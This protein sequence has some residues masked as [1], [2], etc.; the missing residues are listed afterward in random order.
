MGKGGYILL[1]CVLLILCVGFCFFIRHQ[2]IKK[3]IV[4]NSLRLIH[5]DAVN[6]S[7]ASGFI[8]LKPIY[9]I[10]KTV[11]S[12]PRFD[13]F[14]FD[15]EIV[16]W[17]LRDTQRFHSIVMKS[18]SNAAL[19]KEY[20]ARLSLSRE[21]ITP[22]ECKRLSIPC[23]Q[24]IKLEE[25]LFNERLF[26]QPVID[27]LFSLKVSYVTPAGRHH[28]SKQMNYTIPHINF[29]INEYQER[30]R[31]VDLNRAERQKMTPSLRYEIL[32]RD[33]FRC[34]ICGRTAEKDGIKLHVDHIIPIS[35]G[36][37]TEPNNLRTLCDECNLGKSN[38]YDEQGDN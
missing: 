34:V 22:E 12:K 14:N 15:V 29:L 35:K 1:S 27:P 11:D 18:N 31:K 28:Y 26:E 17:V 3:I 7:T 6:R 9:T 38:K 5:L 25:K 2:K 8:P 13:K 30:E 4:T 36:G 10:S 23:K 21:S 32:K 16:H 20:N 33:K 19:W 24:A 37:K